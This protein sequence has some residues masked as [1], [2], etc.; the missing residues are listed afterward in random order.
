[1][2]L[3]YA[4]AELGLAV[5]SANQPAAYGTANLQKI[6]ILMTDGDYNT[7]YNS[8]GIGV[9]QNYVGSCPDA[10]NGYSG[11]QASSQCAS[12]KAAGIT[13]YTVGFPIPS[14]DTT[15]INLLTQC[16]SDPSKFYGAADGTQLQQAFRD[17][18]MSCRRCTYRSEHLRKIRKPPVGC[19]TFA[20]TK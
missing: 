7:Q 8:S 13:I 15:A 4:V 11:A 3:V 19:N 20:A 10:A 18:A 12:M 17:I 5:A 9:D 6:A 1:M 14:S 16:A 2:G